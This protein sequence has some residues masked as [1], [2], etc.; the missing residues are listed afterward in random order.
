MPLGWEQLEKEFLNRFYNTR[1]IVSVKEL[2][3]TKHQKK[4]P[5]I[6]INRWRALSLNCKDKLTEL[7]AV[8]MCTQGMHWKLVYLLQRI[9]PRTF[10]ELVTRTHDM[11]LSIANE[12][13]KIS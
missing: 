9:K 4:E 11:E 8:E 2:T 13:Q 10:E 3:N 12:E 6:Y 5:V 1:R 7:S